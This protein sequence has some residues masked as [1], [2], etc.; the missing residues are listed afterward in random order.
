MT[1]PNIH[2]SPDL[3]IRH[4][5]RSDGPSDP[6]QC[7]DLDDYSEG[8]FCET[9]TMTGSAA[10]EAESGGGAKPLAAVSDW[11]LGFFPLSSCNEIR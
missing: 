2:R 7:L 1:D 8:D 5:G 9:E 6:L 10:V 11:I 4:L 3:D